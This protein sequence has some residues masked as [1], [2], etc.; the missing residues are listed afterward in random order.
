MIENKEKQKLTVK[1]TAESEYRKKFLLRITRIGVTS[2]VL[3][4]ALLYGI[5]YVVNETGY[6]T[7]TV[8]E[9]SQDS[10][11]MSNSAGFDSI[12]PVLRANA[13]EEMDNITEEWIPIDIN[14]TEGD[15]SK[16]NYIAYTF[17]VKNEG[18]KTVDYDYY[19]DIRA[20]TKNVDQATRVKIYINDDVQI[21]AKESDNGEAEP[22]TTAF[23]SNTKVVDNLR[24]GFSVGDVDKYTIVIWVEGEDPDCIDDI[25]GGFMK[26]SMVLKI[27]ED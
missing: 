9:N 16:D 7:I 12:K 20:V 3:L 15:N 18:E 10:L 6:F 22:G 17:F 1:V 5:L 4:L 27:R 24:E 2:M 21:Y 8:A 13:P 23:V 11:V 14:E 25:V 19:I 26:M